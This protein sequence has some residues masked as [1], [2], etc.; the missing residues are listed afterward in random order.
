M[1]H[2]ATAE[3]TF[4]CTYDTVHQRLHGCWHGPVTDAELYEHYADLMALAEIH[5]NCRFWQLDMVARN[6]QHKGF[7]WW[8]SN[9]FAPMAHAALGGPLFIAYVLGAA[10]HA[11]ANSPGNQVI[12]HNCAAADVYPFLFEDPECAQEW[13]VHQQAHDEKTRSR[14]IA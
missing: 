5:E 1:S 12:Q 8:F 14:P 7:G 11:A 4:T 10:H 2:F 9:E 6:W 3:P 13:L